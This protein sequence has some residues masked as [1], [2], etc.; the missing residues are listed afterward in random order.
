MYEKLKINNL[1][2]KYLP[3]LRADL[4][5]SELSGIPFLLLE[6]PIGIH[7]N[8]HKPLP[9]EENIIFAYPL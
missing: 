9:G 6:R 2:K 1:R 5:R 3:R 8:Y 7:L 4:S